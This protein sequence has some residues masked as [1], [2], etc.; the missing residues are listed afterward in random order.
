MILKLDPVVELFK[1]DSHHQKKIENRKAMI[2]TSKTC[3]L[4]NNEK[5]TCKWE[6]ADDSIL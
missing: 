1:L 3:A 6:S 2:T 4:K 5:E